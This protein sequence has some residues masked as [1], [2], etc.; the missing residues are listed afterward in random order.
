[1]GRGA[2]RARQEEHKT[3]FPLDPTEG[4]FTRAL[5]LTCAPWRQACS[6]LARSPNGT[7]CR[8]DAPRVR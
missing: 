4:P 7:G 8:T 3:L 2:Q 1:M 5:W 6:Y